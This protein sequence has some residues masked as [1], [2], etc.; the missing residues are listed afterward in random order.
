M[1]EELIDKMKLDLS[2]VMDYNEYSEDCG[3]V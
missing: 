1:K 2:L 3:E